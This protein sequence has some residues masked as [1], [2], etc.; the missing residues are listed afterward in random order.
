MRLA[1]AE[2][3]G[4]GSDLTE[5]LRT[6]GHRA[7]R[8]DWSAEPFVSLSEY[9]AVVLDLA[10]PGMDGMR[11]LHR[12]RSS[13][14]IPVLAVG[15]RADERYVVRALRGGA[16]DYL[17]KPARVGELIARL[18]TLL[19]RTATTTHGA[20]G[21]VVAG[22]VVVDLGARCVQVARTRVTLTP[23]EFQ[24]LSILVERPGV[25]VGRQHL[26]D[27]VWGD[28][29][30]SVSKSLDVHMACLRSKLDRPGLI[31]T[32]RGYG[33]RWSGDSVPGPGTSAGADRSQGGGDPARPVTGDS[34]R[35][36]GHKGNG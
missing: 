34:A 26:M 9:D 6:R 1:V 23:K 19:R 11:V 10:A 28:A 14:R 12:V 21:I 27:R 3:S 20:G 22:D 13:G 36:P 29:H 15:A 25:P 7:E 5:T 32:I 35:D 8:I 33:Y 17:V 2:G 24:L 31:A 18:E 4:P 30:V 16:D